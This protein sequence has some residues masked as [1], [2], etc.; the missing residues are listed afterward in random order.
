MGAG[1]GKWARLA[2]V[3]PGGSTDY[4]A[5]SPTRIMEGVALGASL[6]PTYIGNV[7]PAANGLRNNIDACQDHVTCLIVHYVQSL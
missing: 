2:D 6:W 1:G 7:V 5:T 4:K 3:R